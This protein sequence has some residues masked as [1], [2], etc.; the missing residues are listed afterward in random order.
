MS[1]RA[2]I[3][4]GVLMLCGPM[5]GSLDGCSPSCLSFSEALC[6]PWFC[7]YN[8]S[9]RSDHASNLGYSF[10]EICVVAIFGWVSA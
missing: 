10:G 1:T 3:R 2:S 7:L 9:P 6:A 8:Q 4:L 5:S